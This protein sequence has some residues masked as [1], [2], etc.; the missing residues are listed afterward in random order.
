MHTKIY[1]YT[2]TGNSLWV[3]RKLAEEL[4]NATLT[5][6]SQK[7]G[8]N[9]KEQADAIGLVFPVYAW[10]APRPIVEYIDRFKP[11][12]S[13]YYF[14]VAT[15]GGQIAGTLTNL[16]NYM[17]KRGITLSSGFGIV[18]PSNFIT[19]GGPGS[20]EKQQE[21]FKKAREKIH[22]IT[23]AVNE[24]KVLPMER[25]VLWQNIIF[26]GMVYNL[27]Y[28]KFPKMDKEFWISGECNSCGICKK[29]CP[30]DNIVITDNGP[31]WQHRCHQCFAC[32]QWCP[33]EIIQTGK[34]T[35][36]YE[37]YHHPDIKVKDIIETR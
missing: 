15:C 29:V 31:Q 14:A 20:I 33:K 19:W 32:V 16:K 24:K 5:P 13:T 6:F 17:K 1:F 22:T 11:N 28:N 30:M 36:E 18:M 4:G 8:E 34:K 23:Q 27:S 2:G 3:A 10:G 35:P 9:P 25:G 26:T 7:N 37:R 12:S 21:K